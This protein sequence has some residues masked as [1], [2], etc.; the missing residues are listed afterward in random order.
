MTFPRSSF[1]AATCYT[2]YWR[3]AAAETGFAADDDAA[4]TPNHDDPGVKTTMPR[5]NYPDGRERSRDFRGRG[6][7][8]GHRR[9]N[10]DYGR[11]RESDEAPHLANRV[12]SFPWL[13]YQK[14][15]SKIAQNRR[16]WVEMP[17]RR[18]LRRQ[19]MMMI[20][21]MMPRLRQPEWI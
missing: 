9:K 19:R 18:Q 14:V 13:P 21:M 3:R 11:W 1:V 6:N 17:G 8:R 2:G 10:L 12:P 5:V 15:V 7:H 16:I 4:P 20:M